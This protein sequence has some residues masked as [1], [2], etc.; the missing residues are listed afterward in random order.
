MAAECGLQ[1]KITKK[2]E[3]LIKVVY[4]K[5]DEVT[6]RDLHSYNIYLSP[7]KHSSLPFV[8]RN[9]LLF[10]PKPYSFGQLPSARSPRFSV[11]SPASPL[12]EPSVPQSRWEQLARIALVPQ[13]W[14]CSPYNGCPRICTSGNGLQ[15]C[16]I[17]P[18]CRGW[19][20]RMLR[21]RPL[22]S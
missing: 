11:A 21:R 2:L 13:Q 22:A 6:D 12:L 8:E 1:I 9:F 16:R 10:T 4:W 18:C 5:V 15:E 14:F 19:G 3:S 20:Q 17:F 7:L